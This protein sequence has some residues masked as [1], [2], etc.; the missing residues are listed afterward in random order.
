MYYEYYITRSLYDFIIILLIGEHS[1]IKCFISYITNIILHE[2]YI[3][4]NWRTFWEFIP[5]I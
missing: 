2:F 5:D 1:K 3:I 4:I